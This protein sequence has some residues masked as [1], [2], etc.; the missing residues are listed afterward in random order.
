[1]LATLPTVSDQAMRCD[2]GTSR[3]GFGEIQAVDDV[4]FTISGRETFGLLGPNRAGKT[5]STS[6]VAG[7][8]EPDGGVVKALGEPISTR[9]TAGKRHIGPVPSSPTPPDGLE[10]L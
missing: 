10:R 4:S 1:M 5:T 9:S 6:M 2:R 8:L 7:L 3:E